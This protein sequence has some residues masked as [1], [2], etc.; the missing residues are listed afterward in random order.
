MAGYKA[1][2]T[3]LGSPIQPD[4]IR[5]CQATASGGQT[6]ARTLLEGHPEVTAL[7]AYNDLVAAGAL[8]ACRELGRQ[9]PE[10]VAIVGCDDIYMAS[11]V[12]PELTTLRVSGRSLGQEATRLLLRQLETA[13]RTQSREVWLQPRLIIRGSAP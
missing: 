10:D 4:H 2:L 8:K 1:Q 5:Y 7:V 13:S 9:V 3:L 6:A 11:L 12:T